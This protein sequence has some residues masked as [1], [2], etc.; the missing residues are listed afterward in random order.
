MSSKVLVGSAGS[1]FV[2]SVMGIYESSCPSFPEGADMETEVAQ[3]SLSNPEKEGLAPEGLS[4]NTECLSG[5][6]K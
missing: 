1:A 2:A 5:N 6:K 3:P 4:V